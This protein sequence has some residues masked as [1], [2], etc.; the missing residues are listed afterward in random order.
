[1]KRALIVYGG[2]DEGFLPQK[3]M[4][5]RIQGVKSAIDGIVQ[6][7]TSRSSIVISTGDV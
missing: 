6:G 2:C 4:E 7:G 5:L 3:E 1:L